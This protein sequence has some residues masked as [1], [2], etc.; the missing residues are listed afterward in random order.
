RPPEVRCGA[1]GCDIGCETHEVAR[2][3]AKRDATVPRAVRM[4]ALETLTGVAEQQRARRHQ[5]ATRRGAVLKAPRCDDGEGDMRVP[6]FE[7]TVPGAGS[8][9]NVLDGPAVAV[10]QDAPREMPP[11][12]GLGV[13]RQ[14]QMQVDGSFCR[15]LHL[16][17]FSH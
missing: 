7:R 1:A 6:F 3:V 15:E 9:D 10:G 14:S 2:R 4:L 17:S 11:V 12:T 5:L 16:P 13:P 8:T